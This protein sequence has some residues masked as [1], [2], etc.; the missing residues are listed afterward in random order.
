MT[1]RP[2]WKTRPVFITSTFRDMQ[3]ERDHLRAHVFPELEERLR[4]RFCHL[5]P[6]DLRWGVE[7]RS[8]G[9]EHMRDVLVLKVCLAEIERSRPF[10]I[11]L[12]GDRYGWVP[13]EERMRAAAQEAGYQ[14]DVAERSVTALEIEFGVLENPDQRKRSRFYFR[15]P[16]P[17]SQ[18]DRKT[19]A[20]YSDAYS[21]DAVVVANY[22]RLEPLKA[23]IRAKLQEW[24][25]PD[26]VRT[27]RAEWDPKA[28][29][30]VGLEAW[31]RQ[32]RDDLWADLE[33][34]IAAAA[35][36]DDQPDTW[37]RQESLAL[38]QFVETES[39]D[40]V[41]REELLHRLVAFAASP[42]PAGDT[43]KQGICLV[44]PS[45]SG[46][47]AVFAKLFRELERPDVL[48]LGHAAGVSGPSVQVD[49]VLRRWISEL[50][51]RLGTPDPAGDDAASREELEQ[52][53]GR[54]LSQAAAASQRVV[55]LI[56]A[57]NQF[58][59]TPAGRY[60]TWFPRLLHENV[61][62]VATAMCGTESAALAERPWC[63]TLEIAPLTEP[64]GRGIVAAI[65]ER[66]R[67]TPSAEVTA[68]LISKCLPD[69]TPAAGSPL[70]LEL[71]V[72][73]LLLL[74]ADDFARSDRDPT[75][76]TPEQRLHALLLH[77]AESLP[78]DVEALY[79]HLLDRTEKIHGAAWAR[80]F[81]NLIALSRSGW[82]AQDIEALLP[83][84]TGAPWDPL[85]FAALRR[86]FRAHLVQRGAQGQWDFFHAQTRTAVL[87]RLGERE[88]AGTAPRLHSVIADHLASLDTADPVH[89]TGLMYHLI[90]ADDRDRAARYYSSDLTLGELVGA[91][92][93]LADH[94]AVYG[95][96]DPNPG[97]EWVTSLLKLPE[98]ADSQLGLLCNRFLF[99]LEDALLNVVQLSTRES[100][101][102]SA[103]ASLEL[104]AA[105][106]PSNMRR[107]HDLWASHSKVGIVRMAQGDLAGA[108]ES[109]RAA[110]AISARLAA[111]D[112][113]NMG[114]QHD[115]S[116]SH[117]N[118]GDVH[119]A[120]GDLAGAVES[121]Q[122]AL[123]ISARLAASDPS[124]MG[125]QRGLSVSFSKVGD[126]RMAHG[127]LAG[128]VESY[129]A[130]LAISVRLAASD[131]SNADWQQEVS[132][133][134]DRVADA[135]MAQG[136]L[137]GALES[138]RAYLAISARFATADPIN[139]L[140]QRDLSVNHEKIGDVREAQG[141]LAGA[142]ESYRAALAIREGLTAVDPSNA[143]WQSDLSVSHSKV[144]NV[145]VAQGD[146]AG[147]LESYRAAL[148]IS[149]RLVASD[150]SNMGRQRD[151]SVSLSQ[152]GDVCMAQRDLAGALE[153]YR[154]VLAISE[155]LAAS[156]RSNA[157]W[158]RDLWV[159]CSK[160]A[161]TLDSINDGRANELWQRAYEIL[162]SITDRGLY[163]S[164]QDEQVLNALRQMAGRPG[165]R[166]PSSDTSAASARP[167]RIEPTVE[168][169]R[170]HADADPQAAAKA[171]AQY[172]TAL[173][174]WQKLPV[175][176]RLITPKPERP[177]GI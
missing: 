22:A 69:G 50:A 54:L 92:R 177:T 2:I 56:D 118:V 165:S 145:R 162:Q 3:A 143:G 174:E 173:T 11:A 107:Q 49:A 139:G 113:S 6:I 134:H 88:P 171:S 10:L 27:Y 28:G 166:T 82:R 25:T 100:L 158:Q 17:Y 153:S 71:A 101:L 81:A 36:A 55:C 102:A 41:G 146:L 78:S 116:V 20:A 172:V 156:N 132:V 18:M 32:V 30:V 8:A 89:E 121:Y 43:H 131:P 110:L 44:G 164:P 35:Y 23:R 168:T 76:G 161:I 58:E 15:E 176:K 57:L 24:G 169:P 150:P 104:L 38:E 45:G 115:L 37:Q 127:D 151:V 144:G 142:L 39:R 47:S 140:W 117:N 152:V 137:A 83:A 5:E 70:W 72:Q 119:V 33:A 60:V 21:D 157:S 31:G 124:N 163:I 98:I 123:A 64:E 94:T 26:R 19:A 122:S 77:T 79:D 130:A 149:K 80:G 40:F 67:K 73:D 111:S 4:E 66:Y 141:D 106:D 159:S 97:L 126:V 105:S 175:W 114:W 170:P 65:C 46:K 155:R 154:A 125:W 84:V 108:L 34:K 99:D 59:R 7:T 62:L 160:L 48:L 133:S 112:P 90:A 13:P 129:Q 138:Y 87:R 95:D 42:A 74:D 29:S 103:F 1:S 63:E 109:H 85:R 86:S 53:F 120:Q 68:A 167:G 136:D 12:I 52:A 128:A 75:G 16:L 96:V 9:D 91:T 93:C 51:E 148:A 14:G 61:R 135:R 147:A